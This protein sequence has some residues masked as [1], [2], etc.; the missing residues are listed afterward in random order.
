MLP[1]FTAVGALLMIAFV[2]LRAGGSGGPL[3]GEEFNPAPVGLLHPA[4]EAAFAA[5]FA[6]LS[7]TEMVLSPK[8]GSFAPPLDPFAG[9]NGAA[10][11]VRA[12]A[13]GRVLFAGPH[14]RAH[15]VLLSHETPEGIVETFYAG[16]EAP[17]VAPGW[18]VRRGQPLASAASGLEEKPG[19][20]F[21]FERRSFPALALRPPGGT[22]ASLLGQWPTRPPDRLA[23]PPQALPAEPEAFSLESE[24]DAVP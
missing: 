18:R 16:L 12:S 23:Q 17:R 13:D 5:E 9:A 1:L 2:A 7:P 20:G 15:A 6:I 8:A 19:V 11:L 10:P 14:L 24:G 22:D 4:R 21:S 3:P